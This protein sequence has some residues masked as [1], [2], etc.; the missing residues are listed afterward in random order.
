[1]PN[2]RI[3]I[4]R[5]LI[6][7]L[8]LIALLIALA[9]SLWLQ[10]LFS[11][12]G[13][14]VAAAEQ[15]LDQAGSD[16]LVLVAS[17]MGR[18]AKDRGRI[19]F[20]FRPLA[21][22]ADDA[23]QV[24]L[25]SLPFQRLLVQSGVDLKKWNIDPAKLRPL[26]GASGWQ[27]LQ[28]GD[29][30]RLLVHLWDANGVRVESAPSPVEMNSDLASKTQAHQRVESAAFRC[31][32]PSP[33]GGVSCGPEAWFRV[34]PSVQ[35]LDGRKRLCLWAHPPKGQ[36]RLV[37]PLKIEHKISATTHMHLQV[38]F[39]DEVRGDPQQVPVYLRITGS[40]L[41]REISCTKKQGSCALDVALSNH[42]DNLEMRIW[43][44]NNGRQLV[45]L[46]GYLAPAGVGAAP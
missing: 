4:E 43:T 7:G 16:D 33:A 40:D 14:A 2:S 15:I 1:M 45:C 28:L 30:Q 3:W 5:A 46:S 24:D 6:A 9:L 20:P 41:Q 18:G 27:Y 29:P 22:I 36:Q 42:T 44:K 38:N 31:R 21:A 13:R 26:K 11:V 37:I 25:T 17:S 34:G 39:A 32:K 35:K 19:L 12:D 23:E 8:S 10:R